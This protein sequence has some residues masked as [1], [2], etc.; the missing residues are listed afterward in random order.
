MSF[1][2]WGSI[3][4]GA[5]GFTTTTNPLQYG[6]SLSDGVYRKVAILQTVN[7]TPVDLTTIDVAEG[8]AFY[9]YAKIVARKS[10]GSERALYDLKGLFYRNTAGNVAQQGSTQVVEIESAVAW[11]ADLVADTGNQTVDIKITGEAA[12]VDWKC[13]V[14]YFKQ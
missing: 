13:E 8:E 10:D 7:A 1:G 6:S 9:V 4:G 2:S 5:G 3:A 14:L 12:N 11:D